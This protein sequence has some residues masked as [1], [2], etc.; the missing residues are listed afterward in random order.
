[1]TLGNPY[2]LAIRVYQELEVDK[3]RSRGPSSLHSATELPRVLMEMTSLAYAWPLLGSAPSGDGH[4]VLVLPGFTAGD[5]STTVL[6]RFLK[7]LGYRP[8]AWELGQNTGSFDL[9]EQLVR[10]F[11]TLTR[12]YDER[13]SIVGQSLGGVFAR[14][15]ARQFAPHVRLVITL[16]SPFSSSGPETTN[17]MVSRLFQYLSGMTREEMRDQMLNFTAE[18]PPVPSTAIYSKSDGVVHWSSCLE[19]EGSQAENI[20]IVGSHSGMAMN[21][22]VYHAIA[23]R[24]SQ[25]MN[26]WQP[27]KR[28]QGCRALLYPAPEKLNPRR[29]CS[30][31]EVTACEN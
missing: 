12:E 4:P 27:F 28:H 18:A 5:E 6:R 30:D 17:A 25:P 9:Q 1:M 31:Q 3:H 14:E 11:Y 20:E 23:D 26:A 2:F 8:L 10:R 19:Y 13:I 22:L 15:L 29:M 16:G 24:L 21:P 7:R